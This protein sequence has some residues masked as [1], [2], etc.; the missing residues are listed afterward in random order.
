MPKQKGI[1]KI[2]GTLNG[3]TY[4]PLN[5]KYLSRVA[6][7]P[8]KKRILTDPAYAH[9]KANNQEFGMASKWSKAIRTG[10]L[11][12][13]KDFQDTTMASRLTGVCYKI[14]KEGSGT[15]GKR[16]AILTNYPQALIGFQ[17]HNQRKLEQIYT[18][19]P[20]VTSHKNRRFITITIPKSSE[21]H[22][23]KKPKTATH[24]QLTAA[25][26]MVSNY[27]CRPD[28]K[29]YKPVAAKQNALGISQN[30]EPLLCKIEHTNLQIQLKTPVKRQVSTHVSLVV[31]FGFQYLKQ[32]GSNWYSYKN[33]RI[34][35]CINLL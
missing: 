23:L 2:H 6:S 28:H 26:S 32:E 3:I 34:M 11:K 14:I 30:T 29:A 9:I 19:I 24:F 16:D 22:L 4:Y 15:H 5:G 8:S 10:I 27:K 7:G 21:I 35:Q 18:P 1:I 17:L 13:A 31:W 12:T 33:T 20:G 25:L